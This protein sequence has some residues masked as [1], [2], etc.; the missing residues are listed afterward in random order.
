[1]QAKAIIRFATAI[2]CSL[3]VQIVIAQP[4]TSTAQIRRGQYLVTL[5]GCYQCHSPKV[6]TTQGPVPDPS[7]ALSGHPSDSPLPPI[8]AGLIG[9]N[10]WGALTT[11]DLTAWAGPWG[12]S[13]AANLTPDGAT[14]LGRWT[15]EMFVR[16]MRTGR[17]MGVGRPILPPMPW[18]DF[19][20]LTDSD[21]RA[22]FAYLHS[23]RP[24]HNQ[25]PMPVPPKQG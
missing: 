6:M 21:L 4:V 3:A 8:P 1:M 19:A 22:I 17:H 12:I 9:P 2:L 18:Q 23:L 15:P 20:R 25:V 24:I 7:R 13:F 10:G 14:G 11:N 16:A 5:S